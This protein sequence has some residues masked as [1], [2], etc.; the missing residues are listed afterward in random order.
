MGLNG[1]LLLNGADYAPFNLYGVGFLWRFL[2]MEFTGTK[3]HV[4]L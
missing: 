4:G 2:V 1:K 3:G